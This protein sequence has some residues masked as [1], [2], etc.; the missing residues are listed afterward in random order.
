[1]MIYRY[2]CNEKW[3]KLRLRKKEFIIINQ[4]DNTFKEEGDKYGLG[5]SHNSTHASF[6]IMIW[7]IDVYLVN[8]LLI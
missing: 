2:L 3:Q 7:R 1:M 4:G 6:L 8:H 5:S